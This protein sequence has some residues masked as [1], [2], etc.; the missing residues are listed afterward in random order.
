MGVLQRRKEKD[1]D[2]KHHA[3]QQ[4]TVHQD[5]LPKPAV[6]QPHQH[7]H[8]QEADRRPERL[9]DEEEIGAPMGRIRHHRR[10]A[11]EHHQSKKDQSDGDGEKGSVR[12]QLLGHGLS[13]GS[14]PLPAA[15]PCPPPP[16]PPPPPPP[17]DTSPPP[18]IPQ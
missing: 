18:P 12:G 15:L 11:V 5:G 14:L 10:S 16:L 13:P 9:L 2:Q 3:Q 8:D 17:P 1:R 6:I 4:E 7:R